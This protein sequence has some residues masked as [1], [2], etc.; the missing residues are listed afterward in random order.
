VIDPRRAVDVYLE[1]SEN[2]SR[3]YPSHQPVA[4]LESLNRASE[5]VSILQADGFSP[6][7][8]PGSYHGWTAVSFPTVILLTPARSRPTPT[9]HSDNSSRPVLWIN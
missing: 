6:M 2:L 4:K 3:G 7:N 8:V 1:L 9:D 5:T